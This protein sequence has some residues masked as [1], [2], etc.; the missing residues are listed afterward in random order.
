MSLQ[1]TKTLVG[2]CSSK[3]VRRG[4][5]EG[6][7]YIELDFSNVQ[8]KSDEYFVTDFLECTDQA[9]IYFRADSELRGLGMRVPE[10]HEWRKED[11][12]LVLADLGNVRL[13]DIPYVRGIWEDLVDQ[14]ANVYNA[15]GESFL[16]GY[17]VHISNRIY[18]VH[19]VN[20]EI[21]EYHQA[22]HRFLAINTAIAADID[23]NIEEAKVLLKNLESLRVSPESMS[24]QPLVPC[25]RDFQTYNIMIWQ[26]K[27]WVIDIQ[28]ASLGP[29]SYDLASLLWDPKVQL[30]ADER[31]HLIQH[32][33]GRTGLNV[34]MV[35]G[36]VMDAALVRYTKS[37]GR[38]LKLYLDNGKAENLHRALI[39]LRLILRMWNVEK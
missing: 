39:S 38:Q 17:P 13:A 29:F 15:S 23:I 35:R 11:R 32:Y 12:C 28:D 9:E 24:S 6:K 16:T 34:E 26:G 2:D 3:I 27:P 18:D 20:K 8:N 31:E 36:S 33:C 30:S 10:I 19:A 14:L 22:R 37:A 21:D 5:I 1:N 4:L 7:S 25:H